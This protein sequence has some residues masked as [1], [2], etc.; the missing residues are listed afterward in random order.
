MDKGVRR[1]RV[2][3]GADEISLGADHWDQ[4]ELPWADG[5]AGANQSG[6]IFNTALNPVDIQ[7][8]SHADEIAFNMLGNRD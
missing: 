5:A 3:P 1:K 2:G 8:L 4:I 6:I 7:Y